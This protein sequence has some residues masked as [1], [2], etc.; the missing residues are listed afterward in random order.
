MKKI[1]N[2]L[3]IAAVGLLLASCGSPKKMAAS[4]DLVSVKSNPAVLEVVGGKIKAE[5]TVSFPEDFFHPSAI[6]EAVPV[7]VYE[8][9][10]VALDPVM[11]QGEKVT[12]NYITVAKAGATIKRTFEFDYVEGME[13]SQ[14]FIVMTAIK[15]DKRIP[16]ASPYKVADGANTTYMLAKKSGTLA[17]APDSYQEIIPETAEAQIL[18]LINSSTVRPSQLKSDE[19]KAFQDY[20]VGLKSDERRELVGTDIV[21]YASPDGKEDFNAS[22]SEK[23]AA[24]ATKAFNSKINN[25]KVAVE[26]TVNATNIEEDWAGF[27]ELLSNSNIEDKELIL[28]VL[29]MYSDPAVREREIKNMSQVYTTLKKDI[30]P[31]LRRAR[32]IA[33]VKF[34]NYTSEELLALISE[35]IEVLDEEALLRAATLV[36]PEQKLAVYTKAIEK[37][38]S[39]RAKINLAVAY[40]ALNNNDAAAAALANVKATECGYYQN[41][42][43]VLELRKGNCVAAAEAFAKS[44][45]TEAKYN[46]AV[47]DICKGNYTAAATKLN[48]SN[49]YNEALVNVLNGNLDAASKILADGKCACKNYLKAVIAARQGKVDAYKAAIKVACTD[50][51]LAARAAKDI[52]FAKVR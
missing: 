27:Q 35:N 42:L 16:F 23:R 19:I 4:A 21:A 2:V 3:M 6:V 36:E 13:S 31:E 17:Y 46:A 15:K 10:E 20:L 18:Y 8:G 1:L 38:N 26:T 33:N 32:F 24:S 12:E 39:E 52:E 45:I 41:A 51:A 49:S 40:L 22:L 50:E 11:L 44:D 29:E 34:T 14:L 30:L 7:L 9:G 28:R 37:F 25:K 48:G 47:I 5:V 43:G